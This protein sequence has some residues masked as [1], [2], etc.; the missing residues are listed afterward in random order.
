MTGSPRLISSR[1]GRLTEIRAN[2]Q[3]ASVGAEEQPQPIVEA[4]IA[5]HT[6][7][8]GHGPERLRE[9]TMSRSFET[10]HNRLRTVSWQQHHEGIPVQDGL[11]QAHI[12]QRGRLVRVSSRFL[13]DARDAAQRGTPGFDPLLR[14]PPISAEEAIEIASRNIGAMMK[15]K[16]LTPK[17]PEPFGSER[18]QEFRGIGLKGDTRVSLVWLPLNPEV[19]RLCWKVEL[20]AQGQAETYQIFVDSTTG[21]ALVRRS[22]TVYISD[23]IY[24]VF[25]NESPTPLSPGLE[26]SG[27][28]QPAQAFRV[29]VKV[30]AVSTNASP[31]GWIEDG[32]NETLGNNVD[33]HTD[34]DND[35]QP[36]LPR[37]RGLPRRI[38]DFPMDLG[39][40]PNSYAN[41]SVVQLFYWNN[42][43]HDRLYELGFT[44]AAGNFQKL[45]YGRGGLENDPVEADAQ[46][47][48][49]FNNANMTVPADGTP[50]RMQMYLFDGPKPQ[51]DGTLDADIVLHEY[52][53]GL[54]LRMVG[55]GGAL[56][57]LQGG[58]LGEGWSDFYAIAM[59]SEPQDDPNGVYPAGAYASYQ[60]G[61]L[62]EN[63][64]FGIRRYPYSTDLMKNPLTL[65]DI[66]PAQASRHPGVPISPIYAGSLFANEVHSQGE[67]WCS[68]LW[69]ARAGLIAKQGYDRGS[70]AILQI[71]TDALRLTPAEPTF[72]EARD[73][74]IEADLINNAGANAE[75]LWTAF[76]KRGMGFSAEVPHSRT[77][78]GVIEAFDV[79]DDLLVTPIRALVASGPAG[80]PFSPSSAIFALRNVGTNHVR[81]EASVSSLWLEMNRQGGEISPGGAE[82][83]LVVSLNGLVANLPSG[84]YRDVL[85]VSNSI[86][87]RV[88][89]RA[90][91]LRVGQPDYLTAS[92]S[93]PENGAPFRNASLT[94]TPEASASGYRACYEPAGALPSDSTGA[95]LAVGDDGFVKVDLL[96]GKKFRFFGQDYTNV[97]VCGNGY[98]TFGRGATDF[99]S[100]LETHFSGPRISAFATDL[101]T[102]FGGSVSAVQLPD[103]LVVNYNAI[104]TYYDPTPNT[105]QAELFFDG[106][107]RVTWLETSTYFGVVGLS[108]GGGMPAEFLATRF[109]ISGSCA[110]ILTLFAPAA[111]NESAGILGGNVSIPSLH[112]TNVVV[113]VDFLE[114]RM[115]NSTNVTIKA[116]ELEAVFAFSVARN[117]ALEGTKQARLMAASPG[118]RDGSVGIEIYDAER[119]ALTVSIPKRAVEGG[120]MLVEKGVVRLNEAAPEAI[121][122]R[123]SASDPDRVLIPE[124]CIVPPNALSTVFPITVLE[125][126]RIN[127]DDQVT[128]SARVENWVEGAAAIAIAD[129]EARTLALG[130]PKTVGENTGTLTNAAV[131]SASGILSAPLT[132]SLLSSQPDLVAAPERL[133]IPAGSSNL[134][135]NL[136][137]QNDSVATGVL[138][139]EFSV[140]AEGFTSA[141]AA[142]L[143]SDDESP[144]SP[145]GPRP[146]DRSTNNSP[147]TDLSWAVSNGQAAGNGGFESGRFAPWKME[148][149]GGGRFS[150]NDGTLDPDG[151]GEP[152]MPLEGRFSAVSEQSAPGRISISQEISIPPGAVAARLRWSD[153][154]LNHAATFHDRYQSFRVEIQSLAGEVL[155]VLFRTQVGDPLLSD[156]TRREVDLRDFVGLQVRVVFV[157]DSNFSYFNVHLD[158]IDLDVRSAPVDRHRVFWGESEILG[159]GQL[160]AT[161]GSNF[162]ALP[163][164]ELNRTY[165]WRV[166][167]ESGAVSTPGPV[168]RF[169]VPPPGPVDRFDWSPVSNTMFAGAEIPTELAARDLFGTVAS[170][171]NG[172]VLLRAVEEI[173]S[174]TVGLPS[175]ESAAPL[176]GF[177]PVM[178]Q[179]SIYLAPEVG[180]ARQIVGIALNVLRPPGDLTQWTLRLKTTKLES[181]DFNSTWERSG[182]TTVVQRNLSISEGGWV[183]IP[184]TTPFEYDGT[185]HLLADFS[186]RNPTFG[187]NGVSFA[188]LTEESRSMRGFDFAGDPLTWKADH[189]FQL[190]TEIPHVRFHAERSLPVAPAIT[191]F[192]N[193]VWTGSVAVLEPGQV[194]RLEAEDAEGH[195]GVTERFS[196][197]ATNDLRLTAP[198]SPREFLQG[199]NIELQYSV[200]NAGPLPARGVTLTSSISG[201]ASFLNAVVSKGSVETNSTQIVASIGELGAGESATVRL[202]ISSRSPG[203]FT[204]RTTIARLE[205]DG[206]PSN[207]SATLV[208]TIVELPSLTAPEPMAVEGSGTN[209]IYELTLSKPAPLPVSVDYRTQVGTASDDDFEAA[210]GTIVIPAGAKGAKVEVKIRDDLKDE[211]KETVFLVFSNPVRAKFELSQIRGTI[212]D[213]EGPLV[214][215][216]DASVLEGTGTRTAMTLFVRLSTNTVETV[217]VQW[218]TIDSSAGTSDYT[219]NRGLVVF[220]PGTRER[221]IIVGI[222]PDSE[223]EPDE[224]FIVSLDTVT[225]ASFGRAKAQGTILNDDGL[226]GE[227][228]GFTFQPVAGHQ[229]VGEPFGIA[230]KARDSFGN[231]ASNYN[232][233]PLLGGLISRPPVEIGAREGIS[234]YPLDGSFNDL[235]MQ[236]IYL[237]REAGPARTL[238]A[239]SLFV[240]SPPDLPLNRFTIRMKHTALAKYPLSPRWE[241][242]W[243]VVHQ[244]NQDISRTGWVTFTF[245]K[246]FA[247]DGVRNLMIDFSFRN[248][249]FDFTENLVAATEFEDA[250]AIIGQSDLFD[251]DP[252]NWSGASPFPSLETLVPDIR[253]EGFKPL[254][255]SLSQVGPFT[256]GAWTGFVTGQAAADGVA[257]EVRDGERLGSISPVNFS[258]RDD[259]SVTAAA[260]PNPVTVSDRF[261]IVVTATNAG[262]AAS[263]AVLVRGVVP[264]NVTILSNSVSEGAFRIEGSETFWEIP[265]LAGRAS[266]S[267][268]I[269]LRAPGSAGDRIGWFTIARQEP[270]PNSENNLAEW[271]VQ[272]NS[273]PGISV[274]PASASEGDS[275]LEVPV[276]LSGPSSQTVL[277]DYAVFDG[278]ANSSDYVATNGQIAFPPGV[279][280]QTI[281]IPL[282]S[283]SL[284]EIDES[285]LVSIYNPVNGGE[286]G[287][288]LAECFI[289]DD[290]GPEL[291]ITSRPVVEGQI[292]KF[293]NW[294]DLRLSGPSVQRVTLDLETFEGSASRGSDFVSKSARVI[295]EPGE[296]TNEGFGVVINGDIDMEPDEFFWVQ[297]S[298]LAG[299]SIAETF[300]KV[301]VLND[302]GLPA[303]L[304]SFLIESVPSPLFV[305]KD[306]LF[307]IMARDGYRNRAVGFSGTATLDAEEVFDATIGEGRNRLA[308]PLGD[309]ESGKLQAI[310]Y[311]NEIGRAFLIN[312]LSLDLNGYFEFFNDLISGLTV[313]LKHTARTNFTTNP[314]WETNG[315]TTVFQG[316]TLPVKGNGWLQIPFSQPFSF[317]GTNQLMIDLSRFRTPSNSFAANFE[318]MAGSVAQLRTIFSVNSFIGFGAGDPVD[319]SGR[320]RS[321]Y[322]DRVVPNIQ[323]HGSQPLPLSGA[324][325]IKF[326]A[327]LW[328]GTRQFASARPQ[329]RIR[330]RD[331]M[332]RSAFSESFT[333]AAPTD[334]DGDG[335]PDAWERLLG[336]DVADPADASADQ[337]HDGSTN[338]EEFSAGTS[339][340]DP[341]DAF[342]IYSAELRNGQFVLRVFVVPGQSYI[343]ER[344][345]SLGANWSQIVRIPKAESDLY[346]IADPIPLAPSQSFYR[347]RLEAPQR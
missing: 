187:A 244:S 53:H 25:Q 324:A 269:Y 83:D 177:Y 107:I 230:I 57:S 169:V 333:V 178:R 96:E 136:E 277:V 26:L 78:R 241:S 268:T 151:P 216:D 301:Q 221:I 87:G 75:T 58:G 71:V 63:Y 124:I 287:R 17:S 183:S 171:F 197:V 112:P 119:T 314:A 275:M 319:W 150:I 45:N 229:Y 310:Y 220:P 108:R 180:P 201:I 263:H 137:S 232:G 11:F 226:P 186:F 73:A 196:V 99:D 174:T 218:S 198:S 67:V 327:G 95:T 329:V 342:S 13:R 194:V 132:L 128:I 250:R 294:L 117:S 18:R 278:T 163:Q 254:P 88:Q 223:I 125:E 190:E 140:R 30:S 52:A 303:E 77:T 160:I 300:V 42:W 211:A 31:A 153:R 222:T 297:V 116:G 330:V 255:L 60:L 214:T 176:G 242:G 97:F 141:S 265:E 148:G 168:W 114:G 2:L 69:E 336:L 273:Q 212:L 264:E 48:G 111:L 154:I 70:Q 175:E 210:S 158:Q 139:I 321:P 322:A 262:P 28:A 106:V 225:G 332:G 33:A 267:A 231:L 50:G 271:R 249:G 166:V 217:E 213:D 239:L 256:N 316:A 283:D 205:P 130:V 36:D 259:L 195:A 34:W 345:S 179:Q 72:L 279:T 343:V 122:V 293:T 21:S 56:Y 79:P 290:D 118:F 248:S 204:N 172:R 12:D 315:W 89:N 110:P 35:D 340:G 156:W 272:V 311:T 281:R 102:L 49:G 66:D 146:A 92:F 138:P 46:D 209:L 235:R 20:Q 326:S 123:L 344:A 181:F 309:Y 149:T 188:T 302:D 6:N 219:A 44:E 289:R 215:I 260:R 85:T 182:W 185:N 109:D 200:H 337:D 243:T 284:D 251:G 299:A 133:T 105:F 39:Q 157:L 184:F 32:L 55:G 189:Q 3:A 84:I 253:L 100:T 227:L 323:F 120:G 164:L 82:Q 257:L 129:N 170:N 22:L 143:W 10:P 203:Q 104:P 228:D 312:A 306:Y 224:R 47:G 14:K 81:W 335:L 192:S 193:G 147:Q 40:P 247:Y 101:N 142:T 261:S 43:M 207:D 27:T 7:L 62:E 68:A 155:G 341:R 93:E 246:P 286:L 292:G 291:M 317:N 76:A 94:F 328:Q 64:Y 206:F 346:E 8:F 115:T 54:T 126:N 15:R 208:R 298:N 162:V 29:K 16:D 145:F 338:L 165:F 339:G 90:V 296:T 334:S 41:A 19:S 295:F 91:K 121:V 98:I 276:V 331:A 4:F 318:L 280:N 161:T 127:H 74:V 285:V 238:N 167:A 199:E 233:S 288:A 191:A 245:S 313:R 282:V 37:P 234:S 305:G 65:A 266:R 270:D 5:A 134:Y 23:S 152:V 240:V 173:P 61:G 113:R 159:P 9:A 347:A 38:F 86:T 236:T 202:D 237:A 252:L 80:G 304:D 24:R 51:R 103:R 144:A 258:V 320:I 308:A 325:E 1:S 59:L 131:V 274:L 307:S 135:F